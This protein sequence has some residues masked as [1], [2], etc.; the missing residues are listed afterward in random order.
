VSF[1]GAATLPTVL[2]VVVREDLGQAQV[3]VTPERKRCVPLGR[4]FTNSL[5]MRP[6]ANLRVSTYHYA[7][8][9]LRMASIQHGG[10]QG[11]IASCTKGW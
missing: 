6:D 8:F 5:T 1:Q 2:L 7:Q 4:V 11:V 9:D 3:L 10:Y